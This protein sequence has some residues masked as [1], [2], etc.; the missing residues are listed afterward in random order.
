MGKSWPGWE[1]IMR[2]EKERERARKAALARRGR[3]QFKR[4]NR[5]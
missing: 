4:K 5:K 2:E 3:E 1:D